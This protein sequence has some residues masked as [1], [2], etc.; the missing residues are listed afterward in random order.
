M[1]ASVQEV[2]TPPNRLRCALVSCIRFANAE[3]ESYV[4]RTGSAGVRRHH[5]ATAALGRCF[6]G[7]AVRSLSGKRQSARLGDSFAG[8][9][10]AMFRRGLP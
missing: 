7:R 3:A 10:D 5:P 8:Y 2:G 6:T 1:R 9:G 4:V